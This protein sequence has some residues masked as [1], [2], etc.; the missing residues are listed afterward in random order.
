MTTPVRVERNELCDLMLAVGP[1]APTL[2]GDWTTRDLAAHLVVRE[3]RPDAAIG[4]VAKPLAGYGEQ[5]RRSAAEGDYEELVE[6]VRSGPPI[7]SPMA[8][9]A[10]DRL[11]NT[12]EFFV[13]HEDVR[14][15]T[16][17]W[18]PRQLD[19]ELENDLWSA[20]RRGASLL[21]RRSPAG[22]VLRPDGRS[23]LA[24]KHP[25]AGQ[26]TVTAAGP[27]GE[28]VLFASGRQAHSVVQL[29]GPA[30]AVESVR[31]ASLG[32]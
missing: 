30:D 24:V 21:A 19:A 22:L 1:D 17:R 9:T 28:L 31:A 32:I 5:V 6:E 16:P 10:V 8:I 3:R 15:A 26:P 11:V 20:F 27:L 2:C 12:I 29:D 4:I 14:R 13:H 23:R 18:V 25:G 7:W